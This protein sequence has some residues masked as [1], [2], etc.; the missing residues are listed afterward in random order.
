MIPHGARGA[1]GSRAQRG[2]TLD[3][4]YADVERYYAAK[5]ARHGA[6][7]L[8]VDWSCQPSQALRFVQLLKLCDLS[9][10]FSLND[11]GCGYGALASYLSTFHPKAAIDYLGTD[12][13][14]AMI[15]RARRLHRGHPS[16][17]FVV[18]RQCPRIADYSV[19]S[20]VMNVKL[21]HPLDIWEEFVAATLHD[22]HRT[23]RSGF[24]VN[25][26][27]EMPPGSPGDRLYRTSP[28]RWSRFCRDDLRCTVETLTGYGL[29]EFTLLAL[30]SAPARGAPAR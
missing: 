17:R 3:A 14:P 12:L 24:A 27:A 18:A 9:A 11:A 19:A 1:R 15:R 21:D 22:M 10:P 6:T 13:S 25:F 4:V 20:G 16:R 29:R 26:M 7:P 2:E 5:V 28:E 30:T 8:G 23:S